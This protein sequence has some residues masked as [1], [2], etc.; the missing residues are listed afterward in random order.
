MSK[1]NF[2]I[3]LQLRLDIKRL[4]LVFYVFRLKY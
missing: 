3:I 2:S 4:L 1:I